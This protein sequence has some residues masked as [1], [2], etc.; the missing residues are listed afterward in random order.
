MN[1]VSPISVRSLVAITLLALFPHPART[2]TDAS[3]LFG[4]DNP[5]VVVNQGEA[6]LVDDFGTSR[7]CF[8]SIEDRIAVTIGDVRKASFVTDGELLIWDLGG[9]R[10][11]RRLELP[12]RIWSIAGIRGRGNLVVVGGPVNKDMNPP[13]VAVVDLREGRVVADLPARHEWGS[14][15]ALRLS[16]DGRFAVMRDPVEY[17]P[18]TRTPSYRYLAYP[19]P[20]P[21]E[22][23]REPRVADEQLWNQLD[24]LSSENPAGLVS[25]PNWIREVGDVDAGFAL[26]ADS[27]SVALWRTDTWEKVTDL[28]TFTPPWQDWVPSPDGR[29]LLSWRRDAEGGLVLWDFESLRVTPFDAPDFY[30][31]ISPAF[32]EDNRYLRYAR[33]APNSDR[34][35]IVSRHLASGREKIDHEETIRPFEDYFEASLRGRF[36]ADGSQL[37]LVHDET[38][39]GVHLGWSET[40]LVSSRKFRAARP[41][42]VFVSDD[43]KTAGFGSNRVEEE[44]GD[45]VTYAVHI[46]DLD[47]GSTGRSWTMTNAG[48]RPS[49]G[50]AIA[51]SGAIVLTQHTTGA[52]LGYYSGDAVSLI[53]KQATR[54]PGFR[55]DVDQHPTQ[56]F[57]HAWS[58]GFVKPRGAGTALAAVYANLGRFVTFDPE[59]KKVVHEYRW[60]DYTPFIGTEHRGFPTATKVVAGDGGRVFLPLRDGGIR[61]VDLAGGG[62]TIHRADLWSLPGNGWFAVTP[63]GPYACS[64]GSERHVFFRRG[65]EIHPFEQ[66]DAQLNRPDLVAAALGAD[67]AEVSALTQAHKRRLAAL[68]A[69]GGG[70]AATSPDPSKFPEIAFPE[71]APLVRD[72]DE[73]AVT[74]EAGAPPGSQLRDLEIFANGVRVGARG[75]TRIGGEA[76]AGGAITVPLAPGS[77]LI[78]ARVTDDLGRAS[79]L[80]GIRVHRSARDGEPDL[81]LLLVGVS[82]YAD[83]EF[84]LAFPAKDAGD[85]GAALERAG[86]GFR[87]V[88]RKAVLDREATREG[89]LAAREFLRQSRPGDRAVVFVA[90]HGMLDE[91]Y[92]Y[93]F[94]TTDIDFDNPGGRGLGYEEIESLFDGVPARER[95]LLMDTCQAG[96]VDATLLEAIDRGEA[97]LPDTIT[98]AA[99]EGLRAAARAITPESRIEGQR[100]VEELFRDLR[101]GTGATVISASGGLEFALEADDWNNGVFT[102]AVI[103]AIDDP[104]A[105]DG[106]GD[107]ILRASELVAAVSETVS[108]LT[109]GIQNPTARS[110]NLA[111]DFPLVG[112]ESGGGPEEPE[113]FL[114]RYLS[115]SSGT[116]RSPGESTDRILRLFSERVD[117]FGK[118]LARSGIGADME[119]YNGT[120]YDRTYRIEGSPRITRSGDGG[121]VTLEYEMSFVVGYREDNPDFDIR[122]NPDVGMFR[123]AQRR[124]ELR[125]RM[126]LRRHGD[127]WRIEA[128]GT[129]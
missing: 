18:N 10:L 52:S 26:A 124:G 63:D 69:L 58:A 35:A 59:A 94:G 20:G 118:T 122:K 111:V 92:R 85:L 75:D 101:K 30:P 49:F 36:S 57:G 3:R 33:S 65:N 54:I 78:E 125:M 62:K 66:F 88:H 47:S 60:D 77:N 55:V 123:E 51:D 34:L 91:D 64:V 7:P 108:E 72:E 70:G 83:D 76:S 43:G 11:A 44:S 9:G 119:E 82:D 128:L 1:I 12:A 48:H 28:G 17:D 90:G 4:S 107:G 24:P 38:S 102:Y 110:V 100:F 99:S 53:G 86:A 98:V 2:Q 22:S 15:Y 109:G 29:R 50:G 14:D 21:G 40:G 93:F 106:N 79:V 89:I 31:G 81:Y 61:V 73:I 74:F 41:V 6:I 127:E 8:L 87:E 129:R 116:R 95:L 114:R 25:A 39:A 37:L 56:R 80:R 42:P 5:E 104:G 32:S 27:L 71:R 96:S 117:Y 103:D 16:R 13:F 113:A 19:I 121:I 23:P 68:A 112:R 97:G 115:W 120:Y 45:D 67:A 105:H 46:T 84:D 126:K